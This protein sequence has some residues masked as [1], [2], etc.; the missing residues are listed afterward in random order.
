[1]TRVMPPA[2]GLAVAATLVAP[3]GDIAASSDRADDAR[4]PGHEDLRSGPDESPL[5]ARQ[6]PGLRPPDAPDL[7]PEEQGALNRK[8]DAFE[9]FRE[10]A[11]HHHERIGELLS[12]EYHIRRQRLVE[13]YDSRI[14]VVH[15]QRRNQHVEAIAALERFLEEH[16]D[17]DEYT[18]DAMFRLANLY[19]DRAEFEFEDAFDDDDVLAAQAEGDPDDPEG[20]EGGLA[21]FQGPDYSPAIDMWRETITRFPDYRQKPGTLYLLGYY[22]GQVGEERESL[23]VY[24][25]LVCENHFDPNAEPPDEPSPGDVEARMRGDEPFDD[26]YAGCQGLGDDPQL[27]EEGWVRGVG[28]VHFNTP[29]ELEEAI[30]AYRRVAENR[31]SEYYD[32]ALYKLAWSYYRN[33]DFLDGIEAFDEAVMY[34]DELVAQ[35]EDPL[36]LRPEAIQYIAVSFTDPWTLE[37]QPDPARSL[38]RALDFYGDRLDEPHVRD[39]FVQLG[40]TFQILQA[41]EQAIDSYRIGLET[42]PLHPDNPVVHQELVNS[43]EALGDDDAADAEAARLSTAYARGTEWYAANETNREAMENVRRIG[44]RMLRAAA[45]NRH[46]R[47]Q[48]A[49][50]DYELDPSDEA[51]QRYLDLY[52]EASDLYD[53]FVREYPTAPEAYEFTYRLAETRFFARDY[54]EAAEHYRWVRDRRELSEARFDDAALSLVQAYEGA[55]R[56]RAEAGEIPAPESPS[57]E[58]LRAMSQPVEPRTIPDL[59]RRQ[60]QA[61]DEYQAMIDEPTGDAGAQLALHGALISYRFLHLDDAEGRFDTVLDRYCGEEEAARAKDG[62]LAIYE[63]RGETERFE[64]T[65]AR[66]IEDECGDEEAIELALA[67]NRSRRFRDAEALFRDERYDDAGQAFYAYYKQAPEE[68]ENRP[69]A[70]YNS[71]V[72]YDRDGRP[73]TAVSLF[74]EFTDSGE[75][76]FQDSEYYIDAL[77]L[78]G[79][80]YQRAFDY[81]RAVDAYLEVVDVAAEPERPEPPGERSLSEIRLDALYNAALLRELDRVYHDPQGAPGT[82]AISLYERY[83]DEEPDRRDSDRAQWAIARAYG[84]AGEP[85]NAARAYAAWR[86]EYGR[87]EG[88]ETDYVFS[89]YRTAELYDEAG[90]QNPADRYRRQTIEAW[91]EIGEPRGTDAADMAA[92]Y[93]FEL[94]EREYARRFEPY[95]ID[96]VPASE[97]AAERVLDELDQLT[98]DIRASYEDIG[99]FGSGMWGMAA[100]VRVGDTLFE[101]GQKILRAPPPRRIEQLDRQHPEEGV[102]LQYE[103]ALEQNL[104]DPK[105]R[106]AQKEWED[107]LDAARSAGISNEWSELAESRLHDFISRE[108]YPILRTPIVEGTIEP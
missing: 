33:D 106:A 74:E 12:R 100:R 95:S 85:Q 64:S 76:A 20:D 88:N 73:R 54:L 38:E 103:E 59:Y 53:R 27:I 107:V 108:D 52:R 18:P 51:E 68:D 93:A 7:T 71:A 44:E 105:Q 69:V 8:R 21:D 24:R 14:D 35:G 16:P 42:D 13:R 10:V 60:Q 102:L 36:E 39:V 79:V 81:D 98:A 9:R 3:S 84:A 28:D 29:G 92:E 25:G 48:L 6:V 45:E 26:P 104:V 101:S 23:A 94:A 65:N 89:Y 77:Y 30:S 99:R 67:Q 41:H 22:L 90:Q 61:L 40:E 43:L 66:F 70:L 37:E 50:R 56:E 47:A 19:L 15:D 5:P 2:L 72:A 82:G 91:E 62:L 86:D 46:R 87:D 97:E 4:A 57:V 32:E 63:A 83:R 34:S 78:R 49:R 80:S 58:D 1:M 96:Q 11:D 55:I 17:H 31:D 75:A